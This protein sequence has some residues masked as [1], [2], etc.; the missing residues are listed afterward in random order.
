M[1][2][3]KEFEALMVEAFEEEELLKKESARA[4]LNRIFNTAEVFIDISWPRQWGHLVHVNM[5]AVDVIH[6]E[7]SEKIKVRKQK[8]SLDA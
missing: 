6:A 5:K 3:L 8:T 2:T 7:R 4:L 1:T